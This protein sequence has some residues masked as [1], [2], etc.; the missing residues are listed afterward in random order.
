[1]ESGKSLQLGRRKYA[2]RRLARSIVFS[3]LFSVL[4]SLLATAQVTDPSGTT[5]PK[6]RAWRFLAGRTAEDAN[7]AQAMEQAQEQ[8]VMLSS[9]VA[10]SPRAA[11]TSAIAAPR[12]MSLDTA[13][14]PLGPAQ[15]MT[16]AY[17]KVT[18]RVTS[19]AI[20][21]S[22]ASG[23]TVYVGTTGG[24]MSDGA[25]VATLR[26]TTRSLFESVT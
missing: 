16:A 1:M 8:H 23:N 12:L 25:K 24:G 9:Q 13:W 19:I 3:C 2:A 21:G 18:G 4:A 26:A 20:D 17:G 15:V 22:D 6:V 11:G 10:A 7:A 5:S 14:Q